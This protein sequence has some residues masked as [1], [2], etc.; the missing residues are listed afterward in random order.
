MAIEKVTDVWNC[1]RIPT[2]WKAHAINKLELLYK[3]WT[4]LKKH[5]DT[6]SDLQVAQENDFCS[7]M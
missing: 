6:E 2:C 3:Q 4:T 1:A 7:K 5:R